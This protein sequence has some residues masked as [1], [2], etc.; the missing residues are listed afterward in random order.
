MCECSTRKRQQ[1]ENLTQ[2]SIAH[3]DEKR[4]N[5]TIAEQQQQQK[6]DAH[7]D[8]VQTRNVHAKDYRELNWIR[9]S[10]SMK[11]Y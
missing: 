11:E 4:L 9:M 10:M 2:A 8:S 3:V 1:N 7:K 5:G 6:N